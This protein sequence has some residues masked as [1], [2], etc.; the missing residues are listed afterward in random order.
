MLKREIEAEPIIDFCFVPLH[1]SIEN[2]E[3]ILM[4]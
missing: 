2:N 1:Y 3:K 4:K